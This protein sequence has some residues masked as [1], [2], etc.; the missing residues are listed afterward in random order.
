GYVENAGELKEYER[1]GQKRKFFS[2]S[3]SDGKNTA[4]VVMWGGVERG[5]GLFPG[6]EVK[7]ESA[8]VKNS[9]LHMNSES[10]LMVKRKKAGIGG[11]IEDLVVS[12]SKLSITINGEKHEFTKEEALK[13][14]NANVAEGIKLETVVELKKS[15]FVGKEMFIEI[16]EGKVVGGSLKSQA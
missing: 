6:A 1:D 5:K 13:I 16:K 14:L 4:R 10:R 11:K 7:I 2:F 15:D 9:E 8:R 12:D 3:I